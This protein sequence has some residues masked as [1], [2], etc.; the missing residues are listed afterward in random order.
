MSCDVDEFVSV[1]RVPCLKTNRRMLNGSAKMHASTHQCSVSQT[2]VAVQLVD[3]VGLGA[4]M[5]RKR[6]CSSG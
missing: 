4:G 1:V 6:S 5:S 2:K 3:M